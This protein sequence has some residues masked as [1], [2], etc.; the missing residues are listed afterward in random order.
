MRILTFDQYIPGSQIAAQARAWTILWL[1]VN[2]YPS[3]NKEQTITGN[4]LWETLKEASELVASG[5]EGESRRL[6]PV[7]A[8]IYLQDDEF[9]LLGK[10]VEAVRDRVVIAN[11]DALLLIDHLLEKA[12]EISK[13]AYAEQV[14]NMKVE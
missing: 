8:T 4:K 7:G 9:R 13:T 3:G 10:A 6:T 12:P 2:G 11:S 1:A 14:K 5:P